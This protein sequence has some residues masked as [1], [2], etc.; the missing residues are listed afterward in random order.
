VSVRELLV[1]GGGTIVPR[2]VREP[3]KELNTPVVGRD[4]YNPHRLALIK[5]A[6]QQGRVLN[7]Q[8]QLANSEVERV[9]L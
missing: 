3:S 9:G 7:S 4:V 5:K 2:D 1:R 6:H 8:R